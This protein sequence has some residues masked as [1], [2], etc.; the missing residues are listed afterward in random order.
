MRIS[1]WSSDVCSSDLLHVGLLLDGAQDRVQHGSQ[2]LVLLAEPQVRV[3]LQLDLA[4]C[5]GQVLPEL[6]VFV[7]LLFDFAAG[8]R[9][10]RLDGLDE[11]DDALAVMALLLVQQPETLFELGKASVWE[12]VWRYV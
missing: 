4:A 8:R 1:D 7:D 6:Q 3:D 5:R 2:L 9:E 10:L 12:R 11:A